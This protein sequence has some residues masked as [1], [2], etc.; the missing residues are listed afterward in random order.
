MA[1]LKERIIE[2]LRENDSLS[3]REI[4][5]ILA[6]KGAAQQPINQACRGLESQGIIVRSKIDGRIKN[7]LTNYT[8]DSIDEAHNKKK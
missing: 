2:L 5:D 3:D 7:F 1:I 8:S 6:G 4:T